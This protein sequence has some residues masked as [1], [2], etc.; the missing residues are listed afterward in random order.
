VPVSIESI[1]FALDRS[2]ALMPPGN[3]AE[4]SWALPGAAELKPQVIVGAVPS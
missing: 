1:V 3:M 2:A 4:V